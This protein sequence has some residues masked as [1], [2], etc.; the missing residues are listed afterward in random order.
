MAI[1]RPHSTEN[2][3]FAF[4][5]LNHIVQSLAYQCLIIVLTAQNVALEANLLHLL[6][7]ELFAHFA[8][9]LDYLQLLCQVFVFL[10]EAAFAVFILTQLLG[11]TL[12]LSLDLF[13]LVFAFLYDLF[14]FHEALLR[15]LLQFLFELVIFLDDLVFYL[16][17]SELR[18]ILRLRVK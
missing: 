6:A 8:L 4:H 15:L 12:L 2:S 7:H 3:N 1:H 13:E 10:L 17:L 14:S 16:L 9:S 11:Y 5:V 18:L